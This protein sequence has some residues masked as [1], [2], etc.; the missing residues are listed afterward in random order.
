MSC[1]LSAHFFQSDENY[2]RDVRWGEGQGCHFAF[3]KRFAR[4]NGH[5]WAFWMLKKIVYFKACFGKIR[6]KI[7][8]FYEILFYDLVIF[9]NF[10]RKFV[11]YLSF[12]IF[13]VWPFWNFLWPNLAFF[14]FLDLVTLE[15]GVEVKWW[16]SCWKIE[17]HQRGCG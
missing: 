7:S 3:L 10:W 11:L 13:E 16:Y 14:T 1:Q 17:N 8:I 12:F 9:T 5:F 15:K 4:K 2:S 6:E